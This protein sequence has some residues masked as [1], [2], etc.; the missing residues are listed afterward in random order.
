MRVDHLQQWLRKDRKEEEAVAA[1][2]EEVEDMDRWVA[3]LLETE[4]M[5]AADMETAKADPHERRPSRKGRW[6]RRPHGSRWS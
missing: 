6:R 4:E 1:A 2:V 5:E 3:S